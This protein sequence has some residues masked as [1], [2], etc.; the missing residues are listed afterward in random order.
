[1]SA[2]SKEPARWNGI[3]ATPLPTRSVTSA[4]TRALAPFPG[5]STQTVC[6][7]VLPRSAASPGLI[8][9]NIS[10]RSPASHLLERVSPQPHPVIRR[11][12]CGD[13]ACQFVQHPVV[14]L[15]L[16][17]KHYKHQL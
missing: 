8:S 15:E 6:P 2:P 12:S 5:P 3:Q 17:K 10:C 14:L 1:M 4:L 13:R 11:A 16:Q 7:S 9:T